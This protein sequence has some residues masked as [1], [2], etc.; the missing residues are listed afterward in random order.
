MATF[1]TVGFPRVAQSK[2]SRLL[3]TFVL[4]TIAIG[5]F[6]F[7]S[8][9]DTPAQQESQDELQT[10]YTTALLEGLAL[11]QEQGLPGPTISVESVVEPID[12]L[13]A[14]QADTAQ[15]ATVESPVD[16]LKKTS[17]ITLHFSGPEEAG[18]ETWPALSDL[19]NSLGES[20]VDFDQIL[21]DQMADRYPAL[22]ALDPEV[23]GKLP[24][25]VVITESIEYA[26]SDPVEDIN[27][28]LLANPN[29]SNN[30]LAAATGFGAISEAD[31]LMGFTYIGPQI[32]Y[33]IE[34]Q[35]YVDIP[36][37]IPQIACTGG[38]PYFPFIPL[39]TCTVRFTSF[40]VELTYIKAGLELSWGLG[41]RL[42]GFG[43][44]SGDAVAD[45][46]TTASVDSTFTT[47]NWDADKYHSYDIWLEQTRCDRANA[48]PRRRDAPGRSAHL[49]RVPRADRGPP[50][51]AQ[52][53]LPVLPAVHRQGGA[54][55]G[56]QD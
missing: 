23:F 46:G 3:G 43:T 14:G 7:I 11:R 18:Y 21:M 29:A 49:R 33:G 41:I 32:W 1:R 13:S 5:T 22:A 30:A 42:P 26:A 54:A 27:R 9:A 47:K 50:R 40:R 8:L 56:G 24:R 36:N 28:A 48:S 16:L 12:A 37:P 6:P 10:P 20:G 17:T 51:G 25:T 38:N 15:S 35:V 52:H 53:P 44:I 2:L 39:P 31:I 4:F 45:P 55:E 19:P 34:E